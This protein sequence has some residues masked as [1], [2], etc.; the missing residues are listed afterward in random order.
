MFKYNL[1]AGNTIKNKY[2]RHYSITVVKEGIETD[3]SS[4]VLYLKTILLDRYMNTGK[5]RFQTELY[6]FQWN[7]TYFLIE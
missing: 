3:I 1:C 4:I 2:E 5:R 6:N 7:F